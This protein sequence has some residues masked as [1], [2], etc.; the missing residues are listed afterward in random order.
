MNDND[1]KK[2][3]VADVSHMYVGPNQRAS[4]LDKAFD[5][6]RKQGYSHNQAKALA[7]QAVDGFLAQQRKKQIDAIRQ[8][9]A[10]GRHESADEM[11]QD[12]IDQEL[13]PKG[14]ADA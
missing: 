8:A 11:A 10:D 6:V 4:L 5:R 9:S 7:A 14:G 12:F 3:S 1:M 13:G 2:S